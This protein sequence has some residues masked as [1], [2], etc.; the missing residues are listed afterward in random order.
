MAFG[1]LHYGFVVTAMVVTICIL[2]LIQR[3]LKNRNRLTLAFTAF[4]IAYAASA[5][6]YWMRG[7]FD[8]QSAEEVLL[9][10]F[11][12][13][14]YPLM[15]IPLFVF[16]AYPYIIEK[17]GTNTALITKIAIAYSFMTGIF[18]F[19]IIAISN[20]EWTH[21][22]PYGLSHYALNLTAIPYIYYITLVFVVSVAFFSVF[23]LGAA[24]QRETDPFY[25][26]RALLL[27]I[28]WL[29]VFLGQLLLLSP[30]LAI[31]QPMV[32]IPRV[33]L[34]ATGVLRTKN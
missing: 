3:Y 14:M 20:V 9:W 27:L 34:I 5:Y 32:A 31:V 7:F 28:G 24:V 15:V 4:L 11:S 18:N 26:T 1:I 17:A 33:L 30:T 13:Y 22:D 8:I 12:N 25:R 19:V 23:L 6:S 21:T 29:C 2:L 10:L 16:L